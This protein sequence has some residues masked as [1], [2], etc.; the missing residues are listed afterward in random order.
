[1]APYNL[2]PSKKNSN[3]LRNTG[4]SISPFLA[5]TD[6]ENELSNLMEDQSPITLKETKK[7]VIVQAP[8]PGLTPKE[9]DITLDRGVLQI[10]GEV[11][12]IEEKDKDTKYY[13]KAK[14]SYWYQLALPSSIDE[15]HE[16]KTTFKNGVL[17]II[18]TKAK[19][20]QAKR[21]ALRS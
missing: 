11:E 16:P 19:T 21:I 12:E 7:E 17:E 8:L 20:S 4:S 3:F 18:F 2:I 1:M 10:K 5:L 15:S 9:I 13:R 14:R 6:F